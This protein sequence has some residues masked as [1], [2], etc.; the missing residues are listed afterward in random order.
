MDMQIREIL[1]AIDVLLE[2]KAKYK[3]ITL[4]YS[5]T[6][7]KP[8]MSKETLD[9]HYGKLYKGYVDKANK[10]KG[11]DFQI[12]GAFLH[13]LYFEQFQKPST[14]NNPTGVCAELIKDFSKFQKEFE[15][16]AMSIEGSGWVYM[17]TSGNIKTI[18]NHKKINNIALLVDWWEHSWALDY[19]ADKAS[20]LKNTWRIIDWSVVNDRINSST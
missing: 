7:L 18:A 12:A 3:Q 16:T 5:R 15:E 10:R 2:E 13:S 20:Y 19:K 14:N 4:P 8:V 6:D 9:Y 1:N 17:D 11:G